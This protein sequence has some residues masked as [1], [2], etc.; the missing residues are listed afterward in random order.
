MVLFLSLN[1]ISQ[2]HF[3]NDSFT[4]TKNTNFDIHNLNNYQNNNAIKVISILDTNDPAALKKMDAFAEKY[5]DQNIAFIAIT[6][7]SYENIAAAYKYE[8]S[9]YQYLSDND[10]KKVFNTYQTGMYKVFPI[11]IILN[12]EGEVI[13]KKKG[14]VSNIEDKL[15][16]RIDKQLKTD[17]KKVKLT[18]F[19]YTIR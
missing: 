3:N 15:A 16:R 7:K 13:F 2:V 9:N 6:D 4:T 11:H 12:K 10:N 5:K 17:N 18:E 19:Q 8:I 14:I 1:M